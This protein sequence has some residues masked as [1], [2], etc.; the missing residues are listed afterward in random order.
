MDYKKRMKHVLLGNLSP[1]KIIYKRI[2][3]SEALVN[4][5]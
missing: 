4:P 1:V 3:E 2:N 5:G